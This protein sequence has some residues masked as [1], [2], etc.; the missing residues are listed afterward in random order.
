LRH[1]PNTQYNNTVDG[2]K[3]FLEKYQTYTKIDSNNL[4]TMLENVDTTKDATITTENTKLTIKNDYWSEKYQTTFTWVQVIN[5]VEYPGISLEFDID[6]NFL[7]IFDTRMLYTMG[8]TSVN[9]S[10]EQAVDIAIENL[11]SYSYEMPDGSIVKDFKVNKDTTMVSL[12]NNPIDYV[13]Y[14]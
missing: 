9:I 10:L 8:D 4:I 3:A 5:G 7:S 12:E 13:N 14:E 2:V 11:K 6:G 1:D